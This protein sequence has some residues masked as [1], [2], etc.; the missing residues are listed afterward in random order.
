[1]NPADSTR[2]ALALLTGPDAPGLVQLAITG[3]ADARLPDFTADIVAVHHRPG[4][5]TSV[6]YDV[7]Y[8]AIA[9]DRD[10][11]VVVTDSFLLSTGRAARGGEGVVELRRGDDV[12]YAWRFPG[13]PALPALAAALDPS[14]VGRWLGAPVVTAREADADGPDAARD[15]AAFAAAVV[16]HRP[17]RRATVR[18]CA[19]GEEHFVKT[20]RRREADALVRRHRVAAEAGIGPQIVAEPMPGTVVLRRAGGENLASTLAAARDGD[21]FP[22]PEGFIAL[23]ERLPRTAL[24]LPRRAPWSERLDFHARAASDAHPD[25]AGRLDRIRDRVETLLASAPTGPVVPVH[26]DP[27]VT[28]VFVEAGAPA[29]FIDLDSLGPGYRVDDL[30]TVLAHLAVLRPLAPET[31]PQ[32][33]ATVE[34]WHR[35]FEAQREIDPVALRA[36]VAAVLVSLVAGSPQ[37][38]AEARVGLAEAW[39]RLA[40]AAD[41]DVPR[42]SSSPRTVRRHE[43]I[44]LLAHRPLQHPHPAPAESANGPRPAPQTVRRPA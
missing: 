9:H 4:A 43:A 15:P 22:A 41:D 5:D 3:R 19:R 32:A 6:R 36:R 12:L 21:P 29:G 2:D 17:L 18:V 31:Y 34:A 35:A 42:P 13:D 20:V 27:S 24:S 33:D 11:S 7:R 8:R 14:T 30:A 16:T 28:N 37:G 1:M 10:T 38:Q 25:L 23:L 44:T 40:A 26:G 39:C